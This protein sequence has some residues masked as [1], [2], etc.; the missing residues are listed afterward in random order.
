MLTII[1]TLIQ[2]RAMILKTIGIENF[3]SIQSL[4]FHV[5]EVNGSKT[6][7]LLEINESGKS[8]FLTA[9]SLKDSIDVNYPSDYY[10]DSLL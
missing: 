7:G 10:D 9:L 2:N 6:F 4:D 3:K 5:N 1:D 8:S